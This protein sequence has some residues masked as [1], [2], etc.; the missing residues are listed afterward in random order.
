VDFNFVYAFSRYRQTPN[1]PYPSKS[2]RHRVSIRTFTLGAFIKFGEFGESKNLS[3]RF[4]FK[5]YFVCLFFYRRF[6]FKI[7]ILAM[8][9]TYAAI[10][11]S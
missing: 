3:G 6:G 9:F 8:Y 4:Y 10:P 5:I 1:A 11:F 2:P 7:Y